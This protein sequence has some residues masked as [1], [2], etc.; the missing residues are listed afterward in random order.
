VACAGCLITSLLSSWHMTGQVHRRAYPITVHWSDRFNV[1]RMCAAN[2]LPNTQASP[3]IM[4]AIAHSHLSTHMCVAYV[5]RATCF[6]EE[7][8]TPGADKQNPSGVYERLV[9]DKIAPKVRAGVSQTLMGTYSS[10]CR[11][12]ILSCMYCSASPPP[13]PPP[14]WNCGISLW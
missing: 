14:L 13:P 6:A 7:I 5:C 9:N 12:V 1:L 4:R 8:S 10:S 3:Y 11:K 2:G